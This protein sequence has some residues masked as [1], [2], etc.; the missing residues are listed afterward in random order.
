MWFSLLQIRKH[1]ARGS[2]FSVSAIQINTQATGNP[3]PFLVHFP[4]REMIAETSE[5]FI[6]LSE[7]LE[8]YDTFQQ[9]F[10]SRKTRQ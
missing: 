3:D 4:Y 2:P 9:R 8:Q 6:R 7:A 10:P 5:L 1:A